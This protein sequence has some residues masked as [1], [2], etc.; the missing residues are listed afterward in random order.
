[1]TA[2][3]AKTITQP[4]AIVKENLLAIKPIVGEPTK[5]PKMPEVVTAEMPVQ[6]ATPG[7]FAEALNKIGRTH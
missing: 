5:K 1:M 3:H 7:T 6:E 2:K 4:K